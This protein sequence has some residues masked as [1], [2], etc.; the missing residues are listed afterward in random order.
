M[1]K[2]RIIEWFGGFMVHAEESNLMGD[3][4]WYPMSWN[5]EATENPKIYEKFTEAEQAVKNFK[6]YV[7][8]PCVVWEDK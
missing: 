7:D 2:Y 4:F 8:K 5:G 1:R 3:R 6:K